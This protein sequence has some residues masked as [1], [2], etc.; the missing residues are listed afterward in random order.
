M[1][2]EE[3]MFP[4]RQ[5][6][7]CVVKMSLLLREVFID[8][9][10][11][12]CSYDFIL[13]WFL[14]IWRKWFTGTSLNSRY[15]I[16]CGFDARIDKVSNWF[17][18]NSRNFRNY[19]PILGWYFLGKKVYKST[20]DVSFCAIGVYLFAIFFTVSQFCLFW[21]IARMF[22]QKKL[23][24]SSLDNQCLL[25]EI[26]N[27]SVMI[28]VILIYSWNICN[29]FNLF[30]IF[31]EYYKADFPSPLLVSFNFNIKPKNGI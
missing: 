4:P 31:Q 18:L 20:S 19:L 13:N 16:F 28:S 29:N 7:S 23:F 2:S 26:R 6:N 5:C 10:S 27:Y 30:L 25:S 22:A 3:L 8:H 9:S 1:N 11:S 17:F 21:L 24:L 15:I 14:W 12:T